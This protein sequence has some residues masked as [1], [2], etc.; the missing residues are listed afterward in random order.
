MIS[1]NTCPPDIGQAHAV[2]LIVTGKTIRVQDRLNRVFEDRY[3][4]KGRDANKQGNCKSNAHAT[5]VRGETC[6]SILTTPPLV[7][8]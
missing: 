5:P 2:V 7:D 4:W 6:A 1:A 3:Y 8:G